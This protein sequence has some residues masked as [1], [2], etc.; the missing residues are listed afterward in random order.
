M[1]DSTELSVSMM[2]DASQ[3]PDNACLM[4]TGPVSPGVATNKAWRLKSWDRMTIPKPF[5]R[6]RVH[7][8]EPIT[9]GEQLSDEALEELSETL[10]ARMIQAERDAFAAIEVPDDLEEPGAGSA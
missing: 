1:A 9:V 4:T 7:Y 3:F 10:R 5:A 8:G 2:C 6:V